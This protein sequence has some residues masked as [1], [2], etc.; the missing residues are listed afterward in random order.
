MSGD[1]SNSRTTNSPGLTTA[2]AKSRLQRFG[3]N[4]AVLFGSQAGVYLLRERRH[5]WDSPPANLLLI[6]SAF[7]IGVAAALTFIGILMLPI[8]WSQLSVVAV[9]ALLYFMALDWLK[10]WLSD[11][12]DLR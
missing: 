5:F 9:V 12:L 7:G 8:S 3:R 11:W 6:S 2:E 4:T 10:I 1:R